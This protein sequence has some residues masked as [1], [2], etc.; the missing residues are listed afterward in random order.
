MTPAALAFAN[1]NV[2]TTSAPQAITVTD[3][4]TLPL[5]VSGV[6]VTGTD[7]A[8][9]TATPAAGCASV[10]PASSCTVNV[11]FA[12]TTAGAKVATVTITDNA[13]GSPHT[14]RLTGTG[15][16]VATVP[17]APTGVLAVAAN[18]S[19]NVSWTAPASNGGSAITGFSVRVIDAAGAQVGALRP[20]AATAT[21]LVVTGLTNGQAYRFSVAATNAIGTGAFSA[22]S[23]AVT[24][25]T[26]PGAPTGVSAVRGNAS[27]TV[28]WTAPA[29]NGG[30]AITGYSVRVINA[31]GTQVGALRPA[32]AAA[33]SLVVTGLTNGQAYRFSV[34]ATNAIG[35]S[36]ASALS[37]AVTPATVPGAPVIGTATAGVAGGA[38]TATARGRHPPPPAA[39]PSPATACPHCG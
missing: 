32:A 1:Q 3:T 4:G 8:L 14:V 35:T 25:P 38:V 19:A 27:A 15:V 20:A 11:T 28:S 5:V 39:R 36:A 17:G 24:L 30:S 33:R 34:T 9:F 22:Q 13:P 37:A 12:P 18:A 6:T 23:A 7:A 29:S 26:A 2:A 16:T 31:A 10:A 21:T